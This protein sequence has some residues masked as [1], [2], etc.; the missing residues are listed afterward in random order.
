MAEVAIS[1]AAIKV[2]LNNLSP[3]RQK[4]LL[5]KRGKEMNR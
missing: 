2:D 4:R 1:A 5:I 3:E